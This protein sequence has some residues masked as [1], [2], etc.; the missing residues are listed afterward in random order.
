MIFRGRRNVMPEENHSSLLGYGPPG[1]SLR[2]PP[3]YISNQRL[4]RSFSQ[5]VK[6]MQRY[7]AERRYYPSSLNTCSSE[8]SSF[9]THRS[10]CRR[11]TDKR[12]DSIIIIYSSRNRLPAKPTNIRA[13]SEARMPRIK[14][15]Q[16][17]HGGII[18][19]DYK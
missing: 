17:N 18:L 12:P 10:M 8:V 16:P 5:K 9:H 6:R 11:T 3:V 19:W 14:H 1:H 13:E 15:N 4:L 7:A 2:E